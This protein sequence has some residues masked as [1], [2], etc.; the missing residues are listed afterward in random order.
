MLFAWERKLYRRIQI[1]KMDTS[2]Y[3]LSCLY[4]V[5][6]V[7]VHLLVIYKWITCTSDC[8]NIIYMYMY[9]YVQYLAAQTPS[10]DPF[11]A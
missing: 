10:V 4:N 2:Q 11:T 9:M 8:D 1:G 3:V 5:F 7:H 6:T